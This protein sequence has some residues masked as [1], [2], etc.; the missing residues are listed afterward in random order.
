MT[1]RNIKQEDLDCI[2]AEME[3]AHQ[4]LVIGLAVSYPKAMELAYRLI[5]IGFS[6][7]SSETDTDM[8]AVRAALLKEGDLL[9]IISFSGMTKSILRAAELAKSRKARVVAITNFKKSFLTAIT[10]HYL[11]TSIQ[12]QALEAEIGTR[13]PFYMIIELIITTLIHKKPKYLSSITATYRSVA[14]SQI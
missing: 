9:F 1:M 5:R 10:D 12:E 4:I 13:L 8:Q 14:D 3:K 11:V 6:G 7:V 2:V